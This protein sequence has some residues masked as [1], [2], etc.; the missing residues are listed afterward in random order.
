MIGTLAHAYGVMASGRAHGSYIELR[1]YVR[2]PEIFFQKMGMVVCRGAGNN[3]PTVGWGLVRTG[4][5][6]ARID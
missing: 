6:S 2:T 3:G 4:R 5:S 1:A